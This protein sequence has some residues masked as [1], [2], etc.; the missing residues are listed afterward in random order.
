VKGTCVKNGRM[1]SC[2]DDEDVSSPDD[3]KEGFVIRKGG[4]FSLD[5]N[6]V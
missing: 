5:S 6:N 4:V 1:C 3:I 2:F